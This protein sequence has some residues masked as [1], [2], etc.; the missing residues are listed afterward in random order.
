[1]SGD[2]L[3]EKL[4][5]QCLK[6]GA[7]GI[8]GLSRTFRIMDDDG[9][10]KL[11][12][13]EFK[14]G[15]HDYGVEVNQDEAKGLFQAF[16]KDGNGSIDFTEFLES[17]RPPMSKSRKDIIDKAFKKLDKTGDGVVTVEDLEGVYNPREHKKYRDGKWTEKQVFEDFLKT[18]DSPNDPDGKVTHEEFVNYYAGVSANVDNDT[19]FDLMMRKAWNL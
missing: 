14:K 19:Y 2:E 7:S 16:D 15:L 13:E 5:A 18:F 3:I 9:N 1:M 6:R 4:R 12:L 10:K 8:K 17:L 11:D